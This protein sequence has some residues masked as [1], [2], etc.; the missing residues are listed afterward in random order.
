MSPKTVGAYTEISRLLLQQSSISMEAFVQNELAMR[1]A[2]AIDFAGLFGTGSSNQ[3]LGLFNYSGTGAVVGGTNGAALDWGKVVDFETEAG[4]ANALVQNMCYLTNANVRGSLKQTEKASG[5][6]QFIMSEM[7]TLN[8]YPT[9]VSNQVSNNL[10]K[11]TGTGLS[12]MAFG[13]FADLIIGMWGGLD[14]QVNPYSLDT[15]GAVRVTAF[16]DVD[17]NLRHPESFSVMKDIIA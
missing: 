12:A 5:T 10:T 14:L 8:G 2:L 17:I 4:T 6:A 11:G 9:V 15:K 3:P 13:N 1:L 7:G 16:Q